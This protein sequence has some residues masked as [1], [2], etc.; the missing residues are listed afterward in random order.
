MISRLEALHYRCFDQL[1]IEMDAYH[2]LAGA[3]GS[4]KSTLIDIP[5]L[6][7]DMLSKGLLP[8]LL[9][10]PSPTAGARAQSLQELI[11]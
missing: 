10:T 7:G 9:E 4:G 5:M 11:H 3:N 2:V 6:L 1:A 8:A